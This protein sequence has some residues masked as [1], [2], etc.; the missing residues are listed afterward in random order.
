MKKLVLL[1]DG[2]SEWNKLNL[3]TGWVD[4]DLSEKGCK[5]AK[6]A[7]QTLMKEG[8]DF[9]VCYTSNLKRAIHSLNITLDTMDRAQLPV[10]KSWKLN[11]RHYGDLQGLNKS[12]TAVKY[13]DYQVKIW[14]RFYDVKPPELYYVD[15]ESALKPAIYEVSDNAQVNQ[16]E[17]L[18]TVTKRVIPYY[19]KTIVKDILAEKRVLI[20]AHNNTLRALVKYLDS[21]T[22]DEIVSVNIPNCVPLVYEFDDDMNVI[23]HYYLEDKRILR[24]KM[25]AVAK[26]GKK[27]P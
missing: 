3:Y 23:K 24:A 27:K 2:E 18:K 21:L 8:Y 4:V 15:D 12:D 13:G 26:E 19:K 5:D 14:R 20:T 17:S 6:Q 25:E 9:D 16:Y 10:I 11:E 1:R 22:E 7:G